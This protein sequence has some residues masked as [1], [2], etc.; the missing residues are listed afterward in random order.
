MYIPS[1]IPHAE[2]AAP[3]KVINKFHGRFD[4][5]KVYEGVDFGPDYKK[6]GYASQERPHATFAAMISILDEQVGD[7]IDKVQE[8]GIS[9]NTIIIFTSDNGPHVEGGADP[10]YFN[11]NG[12]LRGYKRDLYEGGIRVPMIVSWPKHIKKGTKSHHI[13]AFWDWL[14]T[15]CDIVGLEDVPDNVDGLSFKPTI[16][17]NEE[18]QKEHEYLYWEFHEMGGR[19]AIRMGNWKLVKYNVFD[20]EKSRIELYNLLDDIGEGNNLAQD[21][22]RWSKKQISY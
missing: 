17:K 13:S 19:Q 15:I 21:Y 6:G 9:D 20:E 1:I 2:L 14:P 5:E 11:S 18:N 3:H 8:L 16:M 4:P 7:I 22:P 10:D 12:P